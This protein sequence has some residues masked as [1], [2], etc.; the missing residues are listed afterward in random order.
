[1][2]M[3]VT[4]NIKVTYNEAPKTMLKTEVKIPDLQSA[5]ETISAAV[6]NET[7]TV[8][9]QNG[10]REGDTTSQED[11]KS[12]SRRIQNAISNANNKMKNTKTKCEFSYHEPTKRVSI[13]VIDRE[14]EEVIREIPP[15]ET[16]QMIEKMWELAGILV[17]E[18]R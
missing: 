1:M 15:E 10:Q 16:L 12:N 6:M 8:K 3:E 11:E 14:T 7:R 2:A 17:D 13:K 4:N 9:T 18:K 5:D